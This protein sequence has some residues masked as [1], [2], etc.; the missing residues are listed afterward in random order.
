VNTVR[1]LRVVCALALASA[2]AGCGGG[3]EPDPV[4]SAAPSASASATASPAVTEA[5]SPTVAATPSAKACPDALAEDA[6][7]VPPEDVVVPP[8][9]HLYKSSGARFW[10]V[11]DDAPDQIGNRRDDA[12]NYLVQ[13]S[14]Y[15]TLGTRDDAGVLGTANLRGELHRV[16][17]RVSALCA[18]KLQIVYTVKSA[19]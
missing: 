14:A 6:T 19:R 8:Y 13:N 10:G 11:L 7:R 9:V 17:L 15:E 16:Q 18:G 2:A 3:D 12:I 1:G 5:P 4:A